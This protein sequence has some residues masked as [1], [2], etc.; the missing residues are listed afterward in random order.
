MVLT[1]GLKCVAQVG[2]AVVC[3][4]GFSVGISMMM[5]DVLQHVIPVALV[6][7]C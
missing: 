6:L 3:L 2:F 5:G 1:N 4:G 7:V